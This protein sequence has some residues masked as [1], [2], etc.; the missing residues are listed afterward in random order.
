MS[1]KII[2]LNIDGTIRELSIKS[3]ISP[4]DFSINDIPTEALI[5]KGKGDLEREC[6]FNY[7]DHIISLFAWCDGK[8]G[9][10][11][12]HELPPPVDNELYFGNM[13]CLLTKDNKLVD[14]NTDF[15]MEFYESAFGGFEDL[16][17]EDSYSEDD[18][19]DNGSDL[20]DFVV[21]DIEEIE[22]KSYHPSEDS[23]DVSPELSKT[24]KS[25][26]KSSKKTDEENELELSSEL[27]E[28]DLDKE[29]TEED[30]MNDEDYVDGESE[31]S[32]SDESEEECSEC[33]ELESCCV[34]ICPDCFKNLENCNC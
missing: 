9:N 4:D 24:K 33:G 18:E 2:C 20:D 7:N 6:N 14:F 8:A 1:K 16:G 3:T 10:E 22:D 27:E 30:E 31:I 5:K 29:Y 25:R 11:N 12:K 19:D 15:Y 32:D 26:R 34:C 21:D 13:F 28:L 17:S 23:N